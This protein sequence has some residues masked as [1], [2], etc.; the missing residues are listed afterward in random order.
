[1]HRDALARVY[2]LHFAPISRFVASLGGREVDAEGLAQEAFLRLARDG[3]A[4][5]P[6]RA[7]FWLLRVARN[8]TLN[9]LRRRRTQIA[10]APLLA[11][12]HPPMTDRLEA[13]D[14]AT[15]CLAVLAE[16]QRAIVV[17][18]EIEELSYAEIA[19]LL[20]VSIPKVKTDLFRARLR[21]REELRRLR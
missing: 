20:D 1:M 18:R 2:E 14:T 5:P 6:E 8:L 13:R 11:V 12:G 16:E 4:V 9:E 3:G 19:E 21:M 15:R 10:A 17:L 7:R